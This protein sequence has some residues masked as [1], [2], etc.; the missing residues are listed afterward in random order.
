MKLGVF[1]RINELSVEFLEECLAHREMLSVKE[2]SS[3]E[4]W[5]GGSAVFV[6]PAAWAWGSRCPSVESLFFTY[7][8]R[9]QDKMLSK[10]PA[11]S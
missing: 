10:V 3:W 11:S 4:R 7:K 5:D 8:L 2:P 6:P 9:D 1:V